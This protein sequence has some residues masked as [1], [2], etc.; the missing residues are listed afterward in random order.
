MITFMA[1]LVDSL[2]NII[3][4]ETQLTFE[5][6]LSQMTITM[7]IMRCWIYKSLIFC[8]I[9]ASSSKP[10]TEREVNEEHGKLLWSQ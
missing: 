5:V 2:K 10:K 3:L 9:D 6:V 7:T 8:S 1:V 4:R